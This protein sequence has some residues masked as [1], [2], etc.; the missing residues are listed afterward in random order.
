MANSP[1]V[2][3]L[4]GIYPLLGLLTLIIVPLYISLLHRFPNARNFVPLLINVLG[5]ALIVY[6][7]IM[8]HRYKDILDY[9]P[10]KIWGRSTL[11][12]KARNFFMQ[13]GVSGGVILV[14]GVVIR[15][16]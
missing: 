9:E 11:G 13:T 1:K 14:L 15:M 8:F 16:F 5:A 7:F 12:G 6:S 3:K 4:G 10:A 2:E